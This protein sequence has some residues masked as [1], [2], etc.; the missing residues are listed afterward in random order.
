MQE[1]FN[2]KIPDKI[3][4]KTTD[5]FVSFCFLFVFTTRVEVSLD[6]LNE[7]FLTKYFS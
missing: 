4:K 2:P 7:K 6:Y 3:E 5:N 1:S